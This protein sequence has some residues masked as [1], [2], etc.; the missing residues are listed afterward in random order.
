MEEYKSDEFK[1]EVEKNGIPVDLKYFVNNTKWTWATTYAA[2][3]PHWWVVKNS[4]NWNVFTKFVIYIREHGVVR[5]WG[6][7]IGMYL[8]YDGHSYWTIGSPVPE[9]TIINRKIINPEDKDLPKGLLN[10]EKLPYEEE[11]VNK[12]YNQN[13]VKDPQRKLF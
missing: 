1:E 3:A 7:R 11:V 10:L 4:G 8:D 5:R 2:F 6:N 9:T 13:Q 12:P